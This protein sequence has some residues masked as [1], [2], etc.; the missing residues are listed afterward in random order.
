MPFSIRDALESWSS[1]EVGKAIKTIWL[2]IPGAL[3]WCL[4][5][6]GTN[7]VLM[8]FQLLENFCEADV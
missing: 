7:N 4:W 8:E 5:T 2:M 6:R 1:W 3:F